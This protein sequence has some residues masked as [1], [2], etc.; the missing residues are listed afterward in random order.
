MGEIIHPAAPVKP[1]NMR[2]V[3]CTEA[4]RQSRYDPAS[5]T[6]VIKS[7][8]LHP[9]KVTRQPV[10]VATGGIDGDPSPAWLA[11]AFMPS[12]V[13]LPVKRPDYSVVSVD[14]EAIAS[15][16]LLRGTVP[17]PIRRPAASAV[18]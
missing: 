2:P 15:D 8:W 16:T 1:V 4:A 18:Q 3:L 14:G 12:R 11:R 17:V 10:I 9:R 5:E 13:P 7:E 6:A